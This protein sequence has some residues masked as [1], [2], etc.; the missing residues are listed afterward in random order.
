MLVPTPV[1]D[2]RKLS[3][4]DGHELA[5]FSTSAG[6]SPGLRSRARAGNVARS[7]G[8]TRTLASR[9]GSSSGTRRLPVAR[10][11]LAQPLQPCHPVP[12][13]S[14]HGQVTSL[15]TPGRRLSRCTLTVS[16]DDQPSGS[17]PRFRS[18]AAPVRDLLALAAP[19]PMVTAEL[20]NRR[21]PQK[22]ALERPS[23]TEGVPC[24]SLPR[25][26]LTLQSASLKT[27]RATAKSPA[28]SGSNRSP[29]CPAACRQ[30]GVSWGPR[31]ETEIRRDS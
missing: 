1:G 17:F 14:R 7:S 11:R 29:P 9:T 8:Q 30:L 20:A 25:R 27:G 13:V 6:T 12:N 24:H 4:C 19:W 21:S 3:H 22:Y 16:R 5:H 26:F 28:L 31:D 18:T 23:N 15:G 2:G 10:R